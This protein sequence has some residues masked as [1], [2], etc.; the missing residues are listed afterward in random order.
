[1]VDRGHLLNDVFS[2]AEATKVKY[3]TALELTSYL[4]NE[5]DYAPW[6]VASSK[7]NG[8]KN[9]LYYTQMF[10]KFS[11]FGKTI[12]EPRFEQ[13]SWVVGVNQLEK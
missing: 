3:A 9:S 8:L 6:S 13:T 2:L 4:K 11:K 1:M 12:I 7:L 5:P 10:A